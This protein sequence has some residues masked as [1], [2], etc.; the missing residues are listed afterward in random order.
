M[1][2]L[3]QAKRSAVFRAVY[4]AFVVGR[5][6]ADSQV[7]DFLRIVVEAER[8]AGGVLPVF[9]NAHG[10]RGASLYRH[11]FKDRPARVGVLG[12][13]GEFAESAAQP[14]VRAGLVR[15]TDEALSLTEDGF[16]LSNSVIGMLLDDVP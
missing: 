10:A 15:M 1:P 3:D 8:H 12:H 13:D 6:Y 11:V 2:A 9:G 4:G 14:L 7:F 5:A 16:L